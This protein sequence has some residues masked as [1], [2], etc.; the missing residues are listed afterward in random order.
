MGSLP[1]SPRQEFRQAGLG[2][3]GSKEWLKGAPLLALGYVVDG[4][5]LVFAVLVI[6]QSECLWL[7][8]FA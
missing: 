2:H 7:T 5:E 6:A 1:T 8:P 3:D 4:S